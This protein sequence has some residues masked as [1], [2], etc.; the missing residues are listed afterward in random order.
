MAKRANPG[1]TFGRKSVKKK[2]NPY[3]LPQGTF[4]NTSED[5]D[6]DITGRNIPI[7]MVKIDI[8]T[9]DTILVMWGISNVFGA[10]SPNLDINILLR[11]SNID[12]HC[13]YLLVRQA[14]IPKRLSSGLGWKLEW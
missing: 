14:H 13:M 1:S 2:P 11:P 9:D 5:L 6:P 8:N 4:T 10:R 7:D 12:E 3:K